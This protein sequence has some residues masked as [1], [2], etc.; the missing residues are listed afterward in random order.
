MSKLPEKLIAVGMR[1]IPG[2][3]DNVNRL[4]T[5]QNVLLTFEANKQATGGMAVVVLH[6][7]QKLAYIREADLPMLKSIMV[8]SSLGLGA[9]CS[10][11]SITDIRENY[12]VLKKKDQANPDWLPIDGMTTVLPGQKNFEVNNDYASAIQPMKNPCGEI[13]LKTDQ[14]IQIRKEENMFDKLVANNKAVAVNAGYMEA[15]RIANNQVTKLVAAKAPLMVK[16]YIDTP[17]GKVILA[18]LTAMAVEQFRPTD[19]KL[20]KVSVAMMTQ[21]YQELIQT[22]DIEGMLNELTSS[23][24]IKAVL[25]KVASNEDEAV[26]KA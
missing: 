3:K 4:K 12:L 26:A 16:G 19:A 13:F 24:G 5:P 10:Q 14:K 21:A 22:V 9:T 7:G 1:H 20:K 2:A 11:Y 17:V 6:R 15:G 25:A 8:G 23:E 18:N